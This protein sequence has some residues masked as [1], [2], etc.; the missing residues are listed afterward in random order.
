[1]RVSRSPLCDLT[2]GIIIRVMGK[3]TPP[4]PSGCAG[5]R[6]C[7]LSR[8]S[9]T[10]AWAAWGQRPGLS[11]RPP[12]RTRACCGVGILDGE[13]RVGLCLRPPA[14]GRQRFAADTASEQSRPRLQT[15]ARGSDGL[16]RMGPALA[17]ALTLT[18]RPATLP[19][20]PHLPPHLCLAPARGRELLC[21]L[22]SCPRASS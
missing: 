8:P 4:S 13:L 19:R 12:P 15:G 5:S 21:A 3:N 10:A 18:A 9:D 6:S 11:S 22:V 17:C 16:P 20:A 1:M 7:F 14:E 2:N